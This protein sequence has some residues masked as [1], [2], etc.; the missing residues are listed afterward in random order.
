MPWAKLDDQIFFNRKVTQCDG[1]ARAFHIAGIVYCSGQLTDGFVPKAALTLL[2]GMTGFEF[3]K[4]ML[5][6]VL[7]QL[8]SSGLWD[9]CSGGYTIHDYLEYNPSR[10]EALATREAR[11][12]AGRRGG[13]VSAGRRQANAQANAEQMLEQNPT[14]SPSPSPSPSPDP[15]QETTA[16]AV[17]A[18][19]PA[20]R[21]QPV[22]PAVAVMRD[23][24]QRYPARATYQEIADA[25]GEDQAALDRWRGLCR[26][27][28]R[29][30]YNAGNVEGLL[31]AWRAGGL[32]PR[33]GGNGAHADET[34]E[35]AAVRLWSEP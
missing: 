14:P 10:E 8:L 29:R 35:E 16:V 18:K 12:E 31:G 6:Q 22:P 26:Q 32:A 23:E 21:R 33:T 13:Q 24:M 20:K 4:Q 1:Y 2:G 15:N 30:G 25:V 5:E 9:C 34:V 3:D 19:A 11:S 7:E 28:V 17:G 27:W